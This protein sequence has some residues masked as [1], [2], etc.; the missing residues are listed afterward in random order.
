M[1]RKGV[2]LDKSKW[3]DK[4][5]DTIYKKSIFDPIFQVSNH[6]SPTTVHYSFTLIT[7]Y[8]DASQ[9]SSGFVISKL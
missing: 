8:F 5:K 1:E 7:K 4:Q 2:F 6:Y 3:T 9:N